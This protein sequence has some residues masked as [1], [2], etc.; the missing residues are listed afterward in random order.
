M[1]HVRSYNLFRIL[2]QALSLYG[3]EHDHDLGTFRIFEMSPGK[4]P[5][6]FRYSYAQNMDEDT[7]TINSQR[8]MEMHWQGMNAKNNN[9]QPSIIKKR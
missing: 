5:D 1:W 6:S 7:C 9:I 2:R 8:D 4:C 3:P